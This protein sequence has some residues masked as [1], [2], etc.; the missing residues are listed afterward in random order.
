VT[1][2]IRAVQDKLKEMATE[3]QALRNAPTVSGAGMTAMTRKHRP[4]IERIHETYGW[5]TRSQFGEETVFA[6]WLLVQHQEPEVQRAWLPELASLVEE[7]EASRQ[8]YALLFDRVQKGLGKPQRWGTQVSCMEGRAV[9]D[10]VEDATNLDK[11]R[12]EVFMPPMEEY[13]KMMQAACAK[14]RP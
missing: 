14:A 9:L 5:P 8:N 7:G 3:D 12:A 6:F 11:R 1:A 13:M 4:E 2:E 10:P